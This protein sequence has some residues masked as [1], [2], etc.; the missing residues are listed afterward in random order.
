MTI[1]YAPATGVPIWTKRYNGSANGSDTAVGLVASPDSSDVF[2]TGHVVVSGVD[3]FAT[4]AYDAATGDMLWIRRFAHG[5]PSALAISPDGADLFVTGSTSSVSSCNTIAYMTADGTR[6][7]SRLLNGPDCSRGGLAVSPD[8][9]N[10]FIATSQAISLDGIDYTPDQ[11]KTANGGNVPP[12]NI[13]GSR[14]A[15]EPYAVAVAPDSKH[16][17]LTG[18]SLNGSDDFATV[19]FNVLAPPA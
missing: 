5:T 14:R 17:Y 1:A 11:W 7:W 19:A 13:W 15:D 4:L 18:Q 10:L 16:F 2:V 6:T 8:G 3:D 9:L 12:G